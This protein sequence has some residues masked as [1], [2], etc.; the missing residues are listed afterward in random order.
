MSLARGRLLRP[1]WRTGMQQ[2]RY[3]AI[4]DPGTHQTPIVAE[5]WRRRN[6]ARRRA[7]EHERD[8]NA[9]A[10]A[11]VVAKAPEDS[12]C[13]ITYEFSQPEM[14]SLVDKYRNPWGRLR[15]GR[16][17]EDLDALAGTVAY[18]H[19]RSEDPCQRLALVTARVDRIKYLKRPS[20][21]DDIR[22][23]G[24]VTWVGRSSMEIRMQAYVEGTDEPFME[25]NFTFVGRDPE[26]G[27][28][29][30]INA[31]RFHGPEQTL[32]F[33]IARQRDWARKIQRKHATMSN[34]GGMDEEGLKLKHKLLCAAEQSRFMP[35]LARHADIPMR[36]TQLENTVTM[37]PQHRNTAGRI[38]GGFLMR[39]AYELAHATVYLYAGRRP[40]FLEVSEVNFV[41][42]V[43]VGDLVRLSSR[44]LYTSE[45]ADLDGRITVHVEVVATLMKPETQEVTTTNTFNLTYGLAEHQDGSGEAA[46]KGQ[47][48]LRRVVPSTGEEAVRV[49]QRMQMDRQQQEE[50]RYL[51]GT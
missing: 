44:V 15:V 8:D 10:T 35:T 19:C 24:Q 41:A 36:G 13:S 18:E 40:I 34:A 51:Q 29:K 31:L 12:A 43:S 48:Q 3:A 9:P 27:R 39:R 46:L 11:G 4:V 17:L 7:A 37:Q 22:L 5:L 32:L 45:D 21:E 38:F 16:L 28:A 26:T 50:D 49:V 20:L 6:E 33:H 25:S 2:Q 30:Q 23:S 42:P 1:L 47:L 14:G